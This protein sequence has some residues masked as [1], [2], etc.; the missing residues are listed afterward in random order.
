MLRLRSFHFTL[1][2]VSA[3]NTSTRILTVRR[4]VSPSTLCWAEMQLAGGRLMRESWS[5]LALDSKLLLELLSK[6]SGDQLSRIND[7]L[8]VASLLLR[9]WWRGLSLTS[10]CRIL[11]PTNHYLSNTLPFLET[12]HDCPNR[13]MH[14]IIWVS[15]SSCTNIQF[16]HAQSLKNW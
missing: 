10:F 13:A 6:A 14:G 15:E 2:W 16:K 5:P 7:P 8:Q 1:Q 12:W 3:P 9:Q 4:L 11:T